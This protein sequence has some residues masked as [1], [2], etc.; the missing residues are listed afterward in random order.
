MSD[1]AVRVSLTAYVTLLVGPVAVVFPGPEWPLFA[2]GLLVGAV[3]GATVSRSTEPEDILSPT[4][5]LVGLALP[6]G[7]LVPT[8]ATAES[9]VDLYLRPWFAGACAAGL[10]LVAVGF[11]Y[12]VRQQ[13][14]IDALN[15]YVTFE[16]G[17]PRE[18][19]RQIQRAMGALLVLT[20]T[21][22]V[23]SALFVGEDVSISSYVWAPAMLPV[24]I[25]L[26]T[27]RTTHEVALAE[28]GLRVDTQIHDWD[29][30]ERYELTD[31]ALEF[32]REK[33]YHADVA[34]A[35][36]DIESLD[37]VSEALDRYL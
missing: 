16:A 27:N 24:W 13:A 8:V 9:V 29:S 31:H 37:A 21:A 26:L 20:G 32:T 14:R 6:L 23:A 15:E 30:F 7:W 18:T 3:A 28:E 10:W 34:F 36:D 2:C 17:P 35:R 5:V 19:H 25:I 12:H 4:R 11:A 33:W 1:T 22:V